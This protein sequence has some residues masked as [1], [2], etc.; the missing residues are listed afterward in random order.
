MKKIFIAFG[1]ML[2]IVN[3]FAFSGNFE[4]EKRLSF[5]ELF[6]QAGWDDLDDYFG[7]GG[8]DGFYAGYLYCHACPNECELQE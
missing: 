8:D 1:L 7:N 4:I 2:P 3:C 5:E 6:C